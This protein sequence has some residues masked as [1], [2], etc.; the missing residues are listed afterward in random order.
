[1]S[2]ESSSVCFAGARKTGERED[3]L[4]SFFARWEKRSKLTSKQFDDESQM[5]FLALFHANFPLF[6]KIPRT[7]ILIA[8]LYF[9]D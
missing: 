6:S 5:S 7:V 2:G 9:P 4:K 1:M 3:I 8:G